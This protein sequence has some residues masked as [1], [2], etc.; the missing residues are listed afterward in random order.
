MRKMKNKSDYLI[1]WIVCSLGVGFLAGFFTNKQLESFTRSARSF[2]YLTNA[3][4]YR[5]KGEQLKAIG[6]L[7]KAIA[8]TLKR[9]SFVLA[10]LGDYYR[11]MGEID[12][13]KECYVSASKCEDLSEKKKMF[14]KKLVDAIE[15]GDL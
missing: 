2:T 13:A 15:R 6:E 11:E 9:R 14:L 12:L 10:V 4:K 1:V 5:E 3:G 8:V 7:N